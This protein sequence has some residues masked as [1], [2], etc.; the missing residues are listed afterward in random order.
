LL[1]DDRMM[2]M[3]TFLVIMMAIGTA[4]QRFDLLER[5]F[6]EGTVALKYQRDEALVRANALS[7]IDVLGNDLGVKNGD[8]ENL[9]IVVQPK[10]GR[11][12]ARDGQAQ[13]LPAERC[14]GT[15]SFKYAISGRNRGQ[16]GEV[17]VVVRIGEP[18]QSEVAADA[19]RDIPAPA[20][21]APRTPEQRVDDTPALLTQQSQ[22]EVDIGGVLVRAPA[23]PRP[24]AT[25]IAG[26]PD[27]ASGAG[28]GAAGGGA[29]AS[30]VSRDSSGQSSGLTTPSGGLTES[31]ALAGP[32]TTPQNDQGSLT[33]SATQLGRTGEPA[34]PTIELQTRGL[35]VDV[36]RSVPADISAGGTGQGG[37]AA[38]T[39]A[40]A[41]VRGLGNA[42]E[43]GPIDTTSPVVLNDPNGTARTRAQEPGSAGENI[44][45]PAPP[46][47]PCT[48]LPALTLDIR[49]AGITEVIIDSPCHAGTAAELSYETL[50]FGIAIDA[51]GAGSISAAGFQQASDATLRFADGEAVAFN[52][53]FAD[54]ERM[55]RVAL[56][57]DA[58]VKLALHAFE[59]GAVPG[60]P[61]HV[62]EDNPRGYRDV[63]RKGG[64]Y[65]LEYEPNGV[66]QSI[67]VYT[68]WHR[69]GGNSGVVQL[70]LGVDTRTDETGSGI[71]GSGPQAQ[72]NVMIL[73][74][75]SGQI[76]RS[77]RLRVAPLDCTTVAKMTDR[78]ISDG[79]DD[80]I[81]RKR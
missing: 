14:V 55:D 80:L 36:P 32:P 15:Q 67:E 34:A 59:F 5:Y 11:V 6:G 50:R 2:S 48:V 46:P 23:V 45:A 58:P 52:I 81:V 74:S 68:Y 37:F 60:T 42:G 25:E 65:L 73:R 29:T 62:Y 19:Q 21:T 43:L 78:Y 66:G 28:S 4:I 56:V 79:I 33:S 69:T 7:D 16:T 41:S 9:I 71:C 30:G 20:P 49:P 63:R 22:T 3:L 26:L 12:F 31:A 61:G 72:P 54:T 70:M 24:A 47:V 40:L 51:D 38:P 17:V 77:R 39:D 53:P 13:Y 27:T 35:D 10:C 76:E 75:R 8:P 1:K 57:W 64:G 44:V 18:T